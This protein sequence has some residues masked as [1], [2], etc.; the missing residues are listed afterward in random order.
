MKKVISYLLLILFVFILI[1]VSKANAATVDLL[2]DKACTEPEIVEPGQQFKLDFT[3]KNIS[4]NNL[5]NIIVKLVSIEGKTALT[6]FSP[7]GKTTELYYSKIE[8]DNSVDLSMNLIA[9]SQLKAGAYNIVVDISGTGE[10]DGSFDYNKLVGVVIE[11]KPNMAIT[12]FKYDPKEFSGQK[13]IKMDFVNAGNAAVGETMVTVTANDQKY[14]KYYG[15]LESG[16][17]NTFEQNFDL[18][19]DINGKVEI[20]FTDEL[21]RTLTVSKD[22]QIKD[23][24]KTQNNASASK[25]KSTN[26]I[27]NFFKHI[28]GLGD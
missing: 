18:T 20:T 2:V 21:N 7:V 28:F 26:P 23:T 13:K 12:S 1:P 15:A 4:D 27:A 10:N 14:Y 11:N 3:L 16:D 17:E 24:S 9:D 8:K 22:F 19:G 25:K 5:K 6:G